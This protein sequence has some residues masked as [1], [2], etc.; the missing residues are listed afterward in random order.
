MAIKGVIASSG[1]KAPTT[2]STKAVSAGKAALS[3]SASAAPTYKQVNYITPTYTTIQSYNTPSYVP[4]AAP[5]ASPRVTTISPAAVAAGNAQI[6]PARAPSIAPGIATISD[7][8][9]VGGQKKVTNSDGGYSQYYRLTE[10]TYTVTRYGKDGHLL[11]AYSKGPGGTV[12]LGDQPSAASVAASYSAKTVPSPEDIKLVIQSAEGGKESGAASLVDSSAT[13]PEEK[14]LFGDLV[15]Y[16][17]E[18]EVYK[19]YAAPSVKKIQAAVGYVEDADD[20]GEV[21]EIPS[22]SVAPAAITPIAASPTIVSEEAFTPEPTPVTESTPLSSAVF[23]IPS[24]VVDLMGISGGKVYPVTDEEKARAALDYLNKQYPENSGDGGDNELICKY[25]WYL[26]P[27]MSQNGVKY[28]DVA[29]IARDYEGIINNDYGTL[30]KYSTKIGSVSPM[31]DGITSFTQMSQSQ[32]QEVVMMFNEEMI[33]RD[34]PPVVMSMF[35]AG[36]AEGAGSESKASSLRNWMQDGG[37]VDALKNDVI[38]YYS[39]GAGDWLSSPQGMAAVGVGFNLLGA[40][41]A[42]MVAGPAGSIA[43][44]TTMPFSATDL[45]QTYGPQAFK[46]KGDL[47]LSGEY[48]QDHVSSYNS[49]YSTGNSAV[50]NIGIS[51]SLNDPA[52]NLQNIASGQQAIKDLELSL[53]QNWPYFE[54]ANVYDEKVRQIEILKRSFDTNKA[55]FDADGNYIAKDNPPINIDIINTDPTWKI[56]YGELYGKGDGKLHL[57]EL[58][59]NF[60]GDVVVTDE[61]GNEI[62]RQQIKADLYGGDKEIDAAS[63]VAQTQKYTGKAS[64]GPKTFVRTI[65]L[66]PG[67][68][69]EYG[70]KVYTAKNGVEAYDINLAEGI[71][72]RI[73]FS[74]AGKE[75]KV[76]YFGASGV[77]WGAY[78]PVLDDAFVKAAA[79]VTNQG[80][81]LATSPYSTVKINGKVFAAEG[82]KNTVPTAPGYYQVEVSTPGKETWQKTV[83][84]GEGQYMT[85]SD[86]S[87]DI[88]EE[89]SYSSGGSSGGGG[90]GGDSGGSEAVTYAMIIYG[91]TCRNAKV[92]QDDIEIAPEI[93]KIYSISPGY[94]AIRVEKTGKKPWSKTVYC[95]AGDSVTV[96]PALEDET[97]TTTPTDTTPTDTT[98]TDTTPE[99]TTK[100]VYFNSNPISSRVMINGG[101]S[102]EWTPCYVDMPFGYYKIQILKTGYKAQDHTLYV[103]TVIAWDSYADQLAKMEGIYFD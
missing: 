16:V 103:G 96:S 52:V 94:H 13:P 82:D 20:S 15:D 72:A 89:K 10:D 28:N 14:S 88:E 91:E 93:L 33:D 101:F 46:T 30:S 73:K 41:G 99:V 32:Q 66:Q 23:S 102:G 62:G 35:N 51:K 56:T 83:Y 8:G 19:E 67:Q 74:Q 97:T 4:P 53:K 95:M 61:N 63:I 12:V 24:P 7:I 18:S 44:M 21:E 54:A 77:S 100:R 71:P 84:I 47:Q 1:G 2:I 92:Y 22:S 81:K 42:F 39:S 80:F 78:T 11:E 36:I 86:A 5:V 45:M 64:E 70:G 58:D 57:G 26:V 98:P 31:G 55:M 49:L 50:S 79:D 38:W 76:E 37:L 9:A 68:S 75:S 69:M 3:P 6:A 43:A 48:A 90:G 34:I 17:T 40:A 25:F 29:T 27:E 59:T 87:Q 60:V 85:V 65:Y